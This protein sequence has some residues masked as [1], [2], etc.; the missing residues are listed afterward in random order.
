MLA[1]RAK[2]KLQNG[3]EVSLPKLVPAF[4]SKGFGFL[5]DEDGNDTSSLVA[6]SLDLFGPFLT[7]DSFLISAYDIHH[8]HLRRPQQYYAGAGMVIIDSGGYEL[9][10]QVDTAE[11]ID[12]P[13]EPKDYSR[14]DYLRVLD[15]LPV[16][17]SIVVTNAD[18]TTRGE[19][20]D[21]Q[22]EEAGKVFNEF[23][24]LTSDFLV[25]PTSPKRAYLDTDELVARARDFQQF[26]VLGITEKELGRGLVER[27][28]N[29][30]S[31]RDAFNRK[32]IE[33]PIHV[34]GGLDP[35]LTPLY[36]LAGGDLF[37]SLSW[38][39]YAYHGG[40]AV[41]RHSYPALEA[42]MESNRNMS[43]LLARRLSD[44]LGVLQRLTATLNR[45]VE[46]GGCDF[47][48]FDFHGEVF[49]RVWRIVS[50][51]LS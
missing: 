36:F 42:G 20:L 50:A 33:L 49:E 43:E 27:L 28:T 29:L 38:L 44:N 8:R 37:D 18:W 25:K 15:N 12:V 5:I 23:P 3:S 32:H 34:W 51:K 45:F 1:R 46:S 4:S 31:I 40:L 24:H 10:A 35:I 47:T 7:E 39:R 30:A 22:I 2:L 41:C 13:F 9:S 17:A 14:E 26:D 21:R 48:V 6:D 16:D 19:S 11:L